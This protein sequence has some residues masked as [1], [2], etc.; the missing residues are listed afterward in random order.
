MTRR[1]T[2]SA[3][4]RHPFL[5]AA[6]LI[7]LLAALAAGSAASIW[8]GRATLPSAASLR[9]Y[10]NGRSAH[11]WEEWFNRTVLW[12]QATIDQWGAL[13]YAF[14]HAGNK[15][16]VPGKDGWLF[17][18]EEYETGV[19]DAQILAAKLDWIQRTAAF[20][21][22]RGSR[23]IVVPVP[24]KARIY[25]QYL[26][27]GKPLPQA[28]EG[29]YDAFTD[30]VRASR[31]DVVDLKAPMQLIAGT[32]PLFFKTD[33][34]WTLA[35]A[36]LAARTIAAYLSELDYPHL[37]STIAC[38]GPAESFD[39]DLMRFV[40][41]G[42]WRP[43][44]GLQRE[45]VLPCR[46]TQEI[47]QTDGQQALFGTHPIPFTLVGTS[48]SAIPRWHF[49]DFLREALQ[50]DVLNV[51]DEGEGPFAPMLGY[52][53]QLQAGDSVPP[54]VLWEIPER[55][56]HKRYNLDYSGIR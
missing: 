51:A 49:A 31:I 7:A 30:A 56:L 25:G 32:T 2:E 48:Y 39:G 55:Y 28:L 22:G 5:A 11:R 10:A 43:R 18:D 44:L 6:L 12:R 17:T 20:L 3:S 23:L 42:F 54:F 26:A 35:G 16:V 21:H 4:P 24:A 40:P 53:K 29:G 34:H 27:K 33:T 13:R 52:L 38:G 9:D 45:T 1:R 46:F 15:G 50:A 36:R 37:G 19:E 41:T 47:A 14:F 8:K